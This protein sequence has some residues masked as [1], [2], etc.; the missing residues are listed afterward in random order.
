[1]IRHMGIHYNRLEVPPLASHPLGATVPTVDLGVKL[2][3]MVKLVI[4]RPSC[5][6]RDMVEDL[7][8]ANKYE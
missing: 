6:L 3:E 7:Y 5:V 2:S 4:D 8:F 1:M